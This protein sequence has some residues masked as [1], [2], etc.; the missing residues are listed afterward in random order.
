MPTDYIPT[1]EELCKGGSC[2]PQLRE[3]LQ[4]LSPDLR[5]KLYLP[6]ELYYGM[7]DAFKDT[8]RGF[9]PIAFESMCQ[10]SAIFVLKTMALG[11]ADR[12]FRFKAPGYVETASSGPVP[13]PAS[14][15]P[16]RKVYQ[17]AAMEVC[18]LDHK[19]SEE[20][21]SEPVTC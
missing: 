2:Y 1:A 19:R 16:I 10:E 13:V 3:A 8:I 15:R 17:D 9:G 6:Y 7:T 18:S 21:T 12:I 14:M 4:D 20:H 11:V 5:Y